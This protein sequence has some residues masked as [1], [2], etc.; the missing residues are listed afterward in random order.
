MGE[1]SGQSDPDVPVWLRAGDGPLKLAYADPPYPGQAAEHYRDHPDYGGEVDHGELVERLMDEYP[2]GWALSTS[3]Q[4]L[5]EVLAHC[6][7]VAPGVKG[8]RYRAGTGVRVLAWCKPT[9]PPMPYCGIYGWEPVIVRQGRAP[10]PGLRDYLV[11]SPELYTFRTK[12]AGH[13]TGAK[14]AAFCEWVFRWLG[15]AAHDELTD[16]FPGSGA[17]LAAWDRFTSTP[18]LEAVG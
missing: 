4:A 11:C 10:A 7:R 15:A 18:T 14:P 17:V 3:A 1:H 5:A 12:P 13:V 8:R 6:P 9:A 16:L 2:D